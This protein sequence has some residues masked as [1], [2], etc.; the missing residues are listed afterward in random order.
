MSV[1]KV[2][3]LAL[4]LVA[5]V[6]AG[7]TPVST[8]ARGQGV[9]ICLCFSFFLFP[10]RTAVSL[11]H[12]DRPDNVDTCMRCVNWWEEHEVSTVDR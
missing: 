9:D 12:P 7:T 11:T 2:F 5:S 4:A 10:A 1:L 6:L 3:F 8:T